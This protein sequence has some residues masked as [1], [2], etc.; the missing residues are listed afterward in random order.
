MALA[1]LG[2]IDE[3]AL[4]FNELAQCDGCHTDRLAESR[5]HSQFVAEA[6][7]QPRKLFYPAFPSL[8]LIVFAGHLPDLPGAG[9]RLPPESLGVV[10]LALKKLLLRL[11]AKVGLASA[12]AGADLLFIEAIRQGGGDIHLVLPWSKAE[13]RQTSVAPYDTPGGEK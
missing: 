8:Q 2:R 3:A 11:D 13:F 9:K 5:Y 7:G 12:A 4:A 10:R 1:L 6:I